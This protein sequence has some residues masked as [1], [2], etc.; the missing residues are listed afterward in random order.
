M[1]HHLASQCKHDEAALMG[2][3]FVGI[4]FIFPDLYDLPTFPRIDVFDTL[5]R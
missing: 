3:R 2:N 4:P 5:S 1:L